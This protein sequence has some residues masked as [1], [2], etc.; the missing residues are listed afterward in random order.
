MRESSYY[1]PEQQ[2][3]RGGVDLEGGVMQL[4][5]YMSCLGWKIEANTSQPQSRARS[6]V[7]TELI[8]G[9]VEFLAGGHVNLL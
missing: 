8:Q 1:K 6:H 7:H 5:I 4:I 3:L 9:T 2:T